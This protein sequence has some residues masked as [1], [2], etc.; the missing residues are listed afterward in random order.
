MKTRL[1]EIKSRIESARAAMYELAIEGTLDLN[2]GAGNHMRYEI[3][4]SFAKI[5]EI[6][7]DLD[8]EAEEYSKW[9]EKESQED[10][11]EIMKDRWYFGL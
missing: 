4:E 2:I 10:D 6:M 8:R 1:N 5:S 9:L 3:E 11:Y 7:E